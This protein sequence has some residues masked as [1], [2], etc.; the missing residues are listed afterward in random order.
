MMTTVVILDCWHIALGV[1][2]LP[3]ICRSCSTQEA[4]LKRHA[5]PSASLKQDGEAVLKY[6]KVIFFKLRISDSAVVVVVFVL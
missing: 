3:L 6:K 5:T 2:Q 1:F 4:H